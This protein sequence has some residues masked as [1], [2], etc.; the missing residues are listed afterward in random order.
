MKLN[1]R[2]VVAV[3]V[4]I[5]SILPIGSVWTIAT[6]FYLVAGGELT[7]FQ[8]IY[9]LVPPI[10][11]SSLISFAIAGPTRRD[12]IKALIVTFIGIVVF[13]AVWLA[14]RDTPVYLYLYNIVFY[15][16]PHFITRK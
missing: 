12:R 2:F 8:W 6:F 1:L 3:A 16:I 15:E 5:A 4:G 11:I 10:L 7:I 9:T 14:M 13:M